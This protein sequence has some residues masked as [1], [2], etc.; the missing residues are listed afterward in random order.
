MRIVLNASLPRPLLWCT[1]LALLAHVWLLNELPDA[2]RTGGSLSRSELQGPRVQQALSLR[3]IEMA[4]VWSAAPARS[5]PAAAAAERSAGTAASARVVPPAAARSPAAPSPSAP[6]VQ[7]PAG[8]NAGESAGESAAATASAS[9]APAAVPAPADPASTTA[10]TG[11]EAAA[12][13]ATAAPA[14]AA[15]AAP[16]GAAIG[17]LAIP[18]STRL[19]YVVLGESRGRPYQVSATLLWQHDGSQ[20]EA[21][22]E[23]SAWLLGARTQTSRGRITGEGIAPTRFGDRFRSEQAAH[24]QRDKGLISFSSNAPDAALRPGAQDRLSVLL[25]LAAIVGGDPQRHTPG[26]VLQIQVAGTRDADLWQFRVIG[27][28]PVALPG[29]SLQALQLERLPRRE[30]D[31]HIQVWLAPS[32]GYLPARLRITQGNGDVLDQQWL[33]RDTP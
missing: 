19:R 23:V 29:G 18:G 21:R 17:P 10:S 32:L 14:Q 11:A 13:G 28:Q 1:A 6:S 16:S 27:E 7:A 12:P 20:Y 9:A 26:S 2:M 22:Y 31:Q 3:R 33:S 25:Q 15:S 4:P 24:F 30:Y 8:A 5:A